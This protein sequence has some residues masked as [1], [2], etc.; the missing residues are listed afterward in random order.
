MLPPRPVLASAILLVGGLA[1][2]LGSSPPPVASLADAALWE[3]QSVTLEGWVSDVRPAADGTRFTLVDGAHSVAVRIAAA[4][5]DAIADGPALSTGDRVQAS[6]R[7]SRWQGQLRL[8]AEDARDVKTVASAS[9]SAGA[10]T[11]AEVAADPAAWQG[12]PV[13]VRGHVE[14]GRLADGAH[15]VAV[16]GGAWPAEG[17]VQARGLLRWDGHCLCHRFDARE[18]RPWTP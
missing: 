6:G 1:W 13:V 11:L 12:R 8:D 2:S 17:V 3:G 7:L 5:A 9:A 4:G 16:G 15:S 18:V 14:K 10:T